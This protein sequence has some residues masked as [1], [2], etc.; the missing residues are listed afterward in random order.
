MGELCHFC[1]LPGFYRRFVPIFT[2]IKN[3]EISFLKRAL[4]SNA[5]LSVSQL[6]CILKKLFV[7]N[8]SYS[9]LT[10]K[11]YTPYSPAVYQSVLRFKEKDAYYTIT[12]KHWGHS[13]PKV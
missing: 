8:L 12:T 2:D 3:P 5:Q 7:C 1:G 4:N 13:Y 11:N 10:Q 9:I 6:F